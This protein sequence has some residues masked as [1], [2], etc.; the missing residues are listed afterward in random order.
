MTKIYNSEKV[1]KKT[2]LKDS[3]S[4]LKNILEPSETSVN[5]ILNYSKV[6]FVKKSIHI[7]LVEN[8]LN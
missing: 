7:K 4:V 1:R 8:L 5:Y 3:S 6:L 2:G